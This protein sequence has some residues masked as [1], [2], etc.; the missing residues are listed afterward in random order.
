MAASRHRS[1]ERLNW[2]FHRTINHAAA[3]PTLLLFLRNTIR[4]IPVPFYVLLSEW[5]DLSARGHRDIAKAIARHDPER[6]RAG[7]ERHVREAG[8][9]LIAHFDDTGYWSVPG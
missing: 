1:L 4:F 8:R 5:R 6:A 3:S 2:R 9:L 7:A